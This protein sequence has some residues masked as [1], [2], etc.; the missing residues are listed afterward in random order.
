MKKISLLL[1]LVVAS[2][3][4]MAD[5]PRKFLLDHFTGESCG[6]CPYGMYSI[7]EFMEA[8]PGQYIW[9]SHHYG[10]GNDE[11][12]IPAN[13]IVGISLGV[14]GAPSAA[15]NRTKRILRKDDGSLAQVMNF[16]PVYLPEAG[17]V[18]ITDA[19]TAEAS[20]VIAPTFDAASRLLTVAVS[21]QSTCSEGAYLLSI[22]VKESGMIGG[23]HDYIY[24]LT[25][26]SH[27]DQFVHTNTARAVLTNALGDSVAVTDGAY[28]K[29][30]SYTIPAEWNA[31]NCRVV[32]ILTNT[33]TG[34]VINCEE[35][36][37]VSGTD[38]G[39]S[40]VCGP[41]IPEGYPES[42]NTPKTQYP[43]TGKS[44][45]NYTLTNNILLVTLSSNSW[46]KFNGVQCV[47]DVSLYFV[48][49]TATLAPGVYPI[50]DS[51]SNG[52]VY[53]GEVYSNGEVGGSVL[54]YMDKATRSEMYTAFLLVSGQVT[55][56]A[57]GCIQVEATTLNGSTINVHYGEI[58]SGLENVEDNYL[59]EP[60]KRLRNGHLEIRRGSNIYDV[61]GKLLK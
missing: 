20:V 26:A 9:L 44:T 29:T 59:L 51:F 11:Y 4:A 40:I 33:A 46:F 27:W 10:Y 16:H 55:V 45:K 19:T 38:G 14:S 54:A 53:A 22:Y 36:P 8:H 41:I 42:T 39:A 28:T 15:I 5:F 61:Q 12:T 6:F 25:G 7:K 32:A 17:A 13:S 47:E 48:Q 23:Q 30:C 34:A 1:L 24:D 56:Y 57:N 50:N 58:P 2:M 52:T 43:F 18:Y 31:D 35:A 21:G 3:T 60:V 37:V 49:N